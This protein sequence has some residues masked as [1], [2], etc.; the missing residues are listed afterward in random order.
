M[1]LTPTCSLTR[2]LR[3]ARAGILPK[4]FCSRLAHSEIDAIITANTITDIYYVAKKAAG[5]A[6]AREAIANLMDVFCVVPVSKEDCAN[7][8]ALPMKDFEDAL[9][10]VCARRE[11]A[12][13][14]VSRDRDFLA[15][16]A[17]PVAVIAPDALLNLIEQQ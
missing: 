12:N 11:G 16:S 15:S 9:I 6:I 13:W 10:A 4:A 5:D 3:D 7:A 1:F 2:L 17:S 8:L 14:I